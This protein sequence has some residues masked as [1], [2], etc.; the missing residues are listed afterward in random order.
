MHAKAHALGRCPCSRNKQVSARRQRWRAWLLL[1]SPSSHPNASKHHTRPPAPTHLAAV[2]NVDFL[3]G[4]AALG[5][6]ALHALHHRHALRHPPKHH[7]LAVCGRGPGVGQGR[8]GVS[9]WVTDNPMAFRS[10]TTPQRCAVASQAKPCPAPTPAQLCRPARLTQPG[11]GRG[12]DEELGAVGARPRVGHGQQAAVGVLQ[13]K[14][15]IR[16]CVAWREGA[17]GRGGGWSGRKWVGRASATATASVQPWIAAG[18]PQRL[19][20]STLQRQLAL[21]LCAQYSDRQEMPPRLTVDGLAASAVCI[22]KV[23]ALAHELRA[24]AATASSELR[25]VCRTQPCTQSKLQQAGRL[26]CAGPRSMAGFPRGVPP[27][28]SARPPAAQQCGSPA[29]AWGMMR[30]NSEPL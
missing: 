8:E 25:A 19:F 7:V 14:V 10:A 9:H 15:L 12:G 3:G 5:P 18:L 22:L 27:V 23:T 1:S 2:G 24:A 28:A 29:L 17:T 6:Q 11:A 30:W 4:A 26:Q 16:K 20:S 13:L 21:Q